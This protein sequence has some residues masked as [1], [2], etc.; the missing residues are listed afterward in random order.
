[1][2]PWFVLLMI[3]NVNVAVHASILLLLV[4]CQYLFFYQD[5]AASIG[6]LRSGGVYARPLYTGIEGGTLRF[7][8]PRPKRH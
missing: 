2:L 8:Y 7:I 3:V 4:A 6:G 1:M 5:R